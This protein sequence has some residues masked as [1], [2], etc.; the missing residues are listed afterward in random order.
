MPWCPECKMEYREGITVCSDCNVELV[1]EL[2]EEVDLVPIFESE[3]EDVA[4][5]LI[6]YLNFS[7]LSSTL[8]FNEDKQL[9]EV[10]VPSAQKKKAAKL[11][12][13]FYI[14]EIENSIQA[15][16]SKHLTQTDSEE[17]TD[18]PVDEN[19]YE[20]ESNVEEELDEIKVA[21]PYVMK[22]DQY[23]DLTSSVWI[24]LLFGIV[25]LIVVFLNVAGVLSLLNGILPNV[26]MGAMFLAFIYI[27]IS[28]QMKATKIKSEIEVENKLTKDINEWLTINV[29]EDFLA[30]AHDDTISDEINFLQQISDIKRMVITEFGEQKDSYL[31]RIIEEFYNNTFE[32]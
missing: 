31:D 8:Q 4:N 1:A 17:G 26:V 23:K 27:G 19:E 5:R 32:E 22:A 9:F 11:C 18:Y 2:P 6:S 12:K 7:D 21:P 3:K 28:S 13:A 16:A 29:T 25:G 20:D 14:V 30:S 15:E 24:F 10:S